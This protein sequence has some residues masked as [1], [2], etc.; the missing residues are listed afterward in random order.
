MRLVPHSCKCRF[1]PTCG[2]HATDRWANGV[3]NNLLHVRYHHLILSVPWQLRPII[4]LNRE[5][6]FNVL[7]KA[8]VK[9]VQD[10][11]MSQC[12]MRPDWRPTS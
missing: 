9:S 8:A 7:F 12:G 10:W 11:A 5:L 4:L 3:L 2:K 6:C 1:C